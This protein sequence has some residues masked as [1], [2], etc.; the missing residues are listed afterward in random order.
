MRTG[1]AN[2]PLHGGKCPAWLFTHM[3]ALSAAIVEVIIEDAG[4]EEVLKRLSDPYWF[5][6]LGCVVGFDWHSSGLTTTVCG[7]LKEGLT[8]IGPRAGLFFAGGKGRVARNTPVEISAIAEKYPVAVNAD[9]LIYASKM[10]AKVD[11]AAVQDGYQIY[12][13]FFVFTDKGEWSVIQQGMNEDVRQAR[14]YHWLSSA[15]N[16]FTEEPQA[17]IC[18]DKVMES[19][20]L[21]SRENGILRDSSTEM[22]NS[23]PEKLLREL[24]SLENHKQDLCLP[25]SH[26]IPRTS[27]LNKAIYAAYEEQAENFEQLLQVSGVGAGT[28]RALCLVA[29]VAYG[30]KPSLT[31]PVRY[32]FA[33]GGKDGFPFPVNEQDIENSYTTLNRA[34]HKA[35]MG[36]MEQLEALKK[37][38]AWHSET[39]KVRTNTKRQ[40]A[41]NQSQFKAREKIVYKQESEPVD[42]KI[43]IQPGLFE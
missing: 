34:L 31:D 11:S 13:H 1:T 30:V 3:K 8:E 23:S 22:I 18:C 27:Y 2:L 28:L 7:A 40:A 20:N 43:F 35:R 33:H 17:A 6:A 15:V 37:L 9:E 21:V 4:S 25:R 14:R 29:E 41:V 5:Q 24:K 32:S 10:S 39:V 26:A 42:N 38:A 19:L 36:K 12:H 16:D